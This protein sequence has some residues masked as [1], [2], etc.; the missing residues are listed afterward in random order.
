MTPT[1]VVAM[2][3][4]MATNG[5]AAMLGPGSARVPSAAGAG[6]KASTITRRTI[7]VA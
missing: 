2:A 5:V 4:G 1:A 7:A 6:S 3:S